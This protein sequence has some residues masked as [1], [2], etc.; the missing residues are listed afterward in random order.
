[1]KDSELKT[2]GNIWDLNVSLV[3]VTDGRTDGRT[4]PTVNAAIS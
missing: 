2:E 4:G 1:M 3:D